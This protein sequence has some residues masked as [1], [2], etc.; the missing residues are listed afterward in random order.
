M[1]VGG[2]SANKYFRS[3]ASKIQEKYN[4]N[5]ISIRINS[6]LMLKLEISAQPRNVLAG[7][8][9]PALFAFYLNNLIQRPA[10]PTAWPET[11]L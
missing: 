9:K 2:V 11:T 5:L 4:L 10:E 6:P 3:Y 8:I 7:R 1:I